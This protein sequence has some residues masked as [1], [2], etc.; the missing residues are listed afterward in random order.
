MLIKT[1]H[2]QDAYGHR[3]TR[4]DLSDVSAATV[5]GANG[6]GKSTL[7]VE[8]PL[9]ALFGSVAFRGVR[10]DTLA[11]LVRTGADTA[12]V[13]LTFAIGGSEYRVVRTYEVR[14]KSGTSGAEF[15]RR[16]GDEWQ[17]VEA[18]SISAVDAA[19]VETIGCDY[20]AFV[21]G[22]IMRQGESSTFTD[23]TPSERIDALA[24]I[25]GVEHLRAAYDE[26]RARHREATATV[27]DLSGRLDEADTVRQKRA[28]V[29]EQ[30]D[31]LDAKIQQKSD[32]VELF[33]TA[34]K[35]TKEALDDAKERRDEQAAIVD[36]VNELREKLES[37]R[38]KVR[39]EEKNRDKV[40]ARLERLDAKIESQRERL[41]DL[42][43]D[44]TEDAD[45]IAGRLERIENLRRAYTAE[46]RQCEQVEREVAALEE[47]ERKESEAL[48]DAKEWAEYADKIPPGTHGGASAT[49]EGLEVS[50][51]GLKA[52]ARG[53]EERLERLSE[54][55]AEV[56]E[57][58]TEAVRLERL[59]ND[60]HREH[61]QSVKALERRASVLE[62]RPDECDM[63][64]CGLLRDAIKARRKLEA[65]A[66]DEPRGASEADEAA[67]LRDRL[68]DL[69]E[70]FE[71]LEPDG[72]GAERLRYQW[73]D[74]INRV[75]EAAGA[76]VVFCERQETI[77]GIAED[78]QAKRKEYEARE[79]EV[80][81]LR[82][83]VLDFDE[84]RE[85]K[86]RM[87]DS[88]RFDRPASEIVDDAASMASDTLRDRLAEAKAQGDA[89]AK[90]ARITEA[91]E[92]LESER[93]NVVER[94]AYAERNV[95]AEVDTVERITAR[96]DEHEDAWK[97]YRATLSAIDTHTE[98][99][100]AERQKASR[101]REALAKL[102]ADRKVH[103][104]RLEQ[105]HE[106]LDELDTVRAKLDTARQARD[107]VGYAVEFFKVAP[108]I[109]LGAAVPKLEADCNTI[110]AEIAPRYSVAINRQ[111][112][113]KAGE[114][115]DKVTLSVF[116]RGTERSLLTLSGGE[117]FRVDIA[118][119]LALA[120]AAAGRTTGRPLQ[121]LLIDEGWGSLDPEGVHDLKE[122]IERLRA[123]F[124]RIIVV[125]HVADV[126]DLFATTIELER[127]NETVQ[128]RYAA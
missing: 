35:S 71:G 30:I 24:Q 45:E 9:F 57:V 112:L 100:E 5:S 64:H 25:L 95:V 77:A 52:Y 28:D 3:D 93:E 58:H 47:R 109:V 75:A 56:E 26:A 38:Q 118:L 43:E 44:A 87:R 20:T 49:T 101:A 119:R 90:R 125:S 14:T 124:R 85:A 2:L 73:Q 91:L 74:E 68:A 36:T 80:A 22:S 41:D 126:H 127:E 59:A 108:S 55:T 13:D 34:A 29:V 10:G 33:E 110:L 15:F 114:V 86:S 6:T 21:L 113:T 63:D 105:I 11:D 67:K 97:R 54:V 1:I 72:S 7:F 51:Q 12:R 121:T 60:L 61:L 92:T 46:R 107:R 50:S 123:R 4:V 39:A 104:E 70:P 117:R 23:A 103:R 98:Q 62:E 48:G 8:A 78:L 53:L 83:E 19:I 99:L 106:R 18:S 40:R 16:Q 120:E 96:L 89:A 31:R 65:I 111:T 115:R 122:S 116:D 82:G 81:R 102:E 66:D 69:V 37:A 17:T 84:V 76:L 88:V 94:L 27:E 32:D 42:P 128:L 79:A